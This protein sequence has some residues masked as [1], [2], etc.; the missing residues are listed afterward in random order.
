MYVHIIK[1][2]KNIYD[3]DFVFSSIFASATEYL[4]TNVLSIYGSL[5]S[6]YNSF[7]IEEWISA[8]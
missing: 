4:I 7:V 5:K 2:L 1:I 8:Q 6:L 3:N